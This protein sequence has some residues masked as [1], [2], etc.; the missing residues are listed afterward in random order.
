M[1]ENL[2]HRAAQARLQDAH[3]GP[4]VKRR[5]AVLQL[6]QLLDELLAQ[7]VHARRELLPD[8]DERRA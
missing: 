7:H 8:L 4:A 5:D 6:L 1:L 3:G 2:R